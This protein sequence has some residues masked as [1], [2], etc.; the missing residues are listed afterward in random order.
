MKKKMISFL[1]VVM[2]AGIL[3]GCGSAGQDKPLKD[4]PVEKYVTLGEYKGLEVT[5]A[6]VEVE[7][8]QVDILTA[9]TYTN[10][11]TDVPVKI[12]DRAVKT[13]DIVNIDYVGRKDDVAFEGGTAQGANLAIGS[14]RFIDGFEDGLV[15]VMPGETVDL[16]LTFPQIYQ[17]KDL[18]GQEV[19]FTVTVNFI[20][21][22]EDS[23]VA[24]MEIEDVD[25][26]EGF[27]QYARDYLQERADTSYNMRLESAVLDAF[28]N[29]CV[30]GDIPK[31]II[32]KYEQL[33]REGITLEAQNSNMDPENYVLGVYGTDLESFVADFGANSA[34]QD[35][36][37]Q[38][39][40]NAENLGLDDEEL[41]TT[42][43]EYAAR[44]GYDTIEKF[45]GTNTMEDYRDYLMCEKVLD[46]LM[47]NAV[48]KAK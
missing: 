24:S 6:P 33:A 23:V 47:E 39:V 40:A 3:G 11:M 37:L 13:G 19:V 9:S 43:Q 38:A 30:F 34:K 5:V 27:R 20:A 4:M 17:N 12:T 25:T 15:G 8:E 26:V 48:V 42:L 28:I 44:A 29:T 32:E 2:A 36:S 7:E 14:D 22:M 31:A 35:I 18:A 1:A 46:F 10:Y 21:Q 41:N 45:L 16:N